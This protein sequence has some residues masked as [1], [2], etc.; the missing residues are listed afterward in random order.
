MKK[1]IVCI[2]S[3]LLFCSLCACTVEKP[4]LDG[5]TLVTFGA[6]NTSL[7][8]WP[9]E[10]ANELNMHLVNAGVGGN[11]TA[12]G[13]ARFEQDVASADPDFVT[14]CFG[15]N[16][17]YRKN[18]IDPQVAPEEYRQNLTEMVER[19]R[20]LDAVPIL[21]T[22]PV[23]TETASGGAARYPE[24]SVNA[25]LDVYVN[26]MREVAKETD[27]DLVDIHAVCDEHYS[28]AEFLSSDGVHLSPLGNKVFADALIS[29]MTAHFRQ[30]L[31]A[32]RVERPTAPT[33]QKGPWTKSLIPEAPEGWRILYPGTVV[34]DTDENGHVVFSNT[35]GEWP[36]VHYS[37]KLTDSIA[38]PVAGSYLTVDLELKAATHIL[39]FFNGDTPTVPTENQYLSLTSA[40]KTQ[41]PSLRTSGDDILGGQHVQCTIPLSALTGGRYLRDDA[42]LLFSGVKMFIIGDA[43]KTVTVNE[44]SITATK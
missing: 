1:A 22:S 20:A 29:Y 12:H 14:I 6:S 21:I 8:R 23:I 36:E 35:T 28:A 17:F 11:T 43:G 42:T 25:A 15:T 41:L 33:A 2:L 38:V 13:L 39:L 30:D 4:L 40:I 19:T 37:P 7:S 3:V 31:D 5:A 9:S 10:A 16:D 24:G 32:P 27:T 18:G 44:L 34:A 26:I